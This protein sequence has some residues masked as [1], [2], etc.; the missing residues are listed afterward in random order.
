MHHVILSDQSYAEA[1]RLAAAS[2]IE[3]VNKFVE[4][5]VASY[6]MADPNDFDHY[7]TAEVLA[8]LD[9]AVEEADS[10][11]LLNQ[12]QVKKHLAANREAWLK[13]RAS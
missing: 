13:N 2:G 11:A 5:L 4:V 8:D 3:D 7:F 1:K 10:G 6:G 9:R 12:D